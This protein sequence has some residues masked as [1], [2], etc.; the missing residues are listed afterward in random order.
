[1]TIGL[2]IGRPDCTIPTCGVDWIVTPQPVVL[3]WWP[4]SE[5][6]GKLFTTIASWRGA[7]G[8]L[9]FQEKTYGLRVHQFRRFVDLPRLTGRQF[10][11]ALAIHPAETKDLTL[12]SSKGWLLV[13]P[14]IVA[15]DPLSYQ[16]YIGRSRAEFS[17]AKDIYVQS[18]GGWIS[19]RS[20]CYLAS[21]K[22][23]LTQETGF[24]SH[25]PTG[26]GLLAYSTLEEAVAGVE[27]ITR[28]PERHA[29]AARA[30]A[31]EYFDSDKV[32]ARLLQ[33]LGVA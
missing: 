1:V 32:L 33:K 7:Y 14:E 21:G 18:H 13:D 5:T 23:V 28:H 25:Y 4:L 11:L 30:L 27:E 10:E 19:D 6:V 2:N 20:L 29:R 15:A 3:E 16:N 31:E 12:L 22:P 9:E 26:E 17:V 8:P 24:S